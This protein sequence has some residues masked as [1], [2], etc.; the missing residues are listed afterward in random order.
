MHSQL[1]NWSECEMATM[2]VFPFS[3]YILHDVEQPHTSVLLSL[4]F[5]HQ[6]HGCFVIFVD[7]CVS[8]SYTISFLP[9]SK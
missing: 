5:H 3:L 8:D 6:V 4:S 9:T 7:S 2:K 1:D